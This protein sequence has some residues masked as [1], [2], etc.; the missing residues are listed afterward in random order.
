MGEKGKRDS[1]LVAQDCRCSPPAGVKYA[2]SDHAIPLEWEQWEMC[3]LQPWH[4]MADVYLSALQVWTV[5][6]CSPSKRQSTRLRVTSA[7]HVWGDC[8]LCINSESRKRNQRL[9]LAG[10]CPNQ[11]ILF[12]GNNEVSQS[13][14]CTQMLFFHYCALWNRYSTEKGICVSRTMVIF[15]KGIRSKACNGI[16]EPIT[17]AFNGPVVLVRS[18]YFWAVTSRAVN[19]GEQIKII[20]IYSISKIL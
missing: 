7:A 11:R 4:T 14:V 18:S 17:S 10:N 1:S 15:R 9:C 8:C 19:W 12:W 13:T 20:Y 2:A 16:Q 3:P 6:T 5:T